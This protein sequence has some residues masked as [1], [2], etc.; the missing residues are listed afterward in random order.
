MDES[1]GFGYTAHLLGLPDAFL[2]QITE[3]SEGVQCRIPAMWSTSKNNQQ[4][5]EIQSCP[6]HD[7]TV[8]NFFE[9]LTTLDSRI[10]DPSSISDP[11]TT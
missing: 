5:E 1:L 4:R 8:P 11:C 9:W 10:S 2:H 3:G 7:G 6:L